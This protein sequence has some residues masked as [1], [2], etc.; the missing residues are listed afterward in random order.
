MNETKKSP[1]LAS[2]VN[3]ETDGFKDDDNTTTMDYAQ[4][5]DKYLAHVVENGTR[6]EMKVK[7]VNLSQNIYNMVFSEL[8]EIS[9]GVSD[10]ECQVKIRALQES[11]NEMTLVKK[12]VTRKLV[13]KNSINY[14]VKGSLSKAK[15]RE[16]SDNESDGSSKQEEQDHELVDIDLDSEDDLVEYARKIDCRAAVK[17]RTLIDNNAPKEEVMKVL[18]EIITIYHADTASKVNTVTV[19]QADQKK[20]LYKTVKEVENNKKKFDKKLQKLS[21]EVAQ[22]TAARNK[23]SGLIENVQKALI[24]RA[25]KEPWNPVT[26]AYRLSKRT[27]KTSNWHCYYV[28]ENLLETFEKDLPGERIADTKTMSQ[29]DRMVYTCR[30]NARVVMLSKFWSAGW[31]KHIQDFREW[32]TDSETHKENPC[33]SMVQEYLEKTLQYGKEDAEQIMKEE[34]LMIEPGTEKQN[35]MADN[36]NFPTSLDVTFVTEEAAHRVLTG[37]K[38][39]VNIH[40]GMPKGNVKVRVADEMMTKYRWQLFKQMELK[41]NF[42]EDG[43]LHPDGSRRR[44]SAC[45]RYSTKTQDGGDPKRVGIRIYVRKRFGPGSSWEHAKDADDSVQIPTWVEEWDQ[46]QYGRPEKYM[47]PAQAEVYDPNVDPKGNRAQESNDWN[48]VGRGGRHQNL[49]SKLKSRGLQQGYMSDSSSSSGSARSGKRGGRGG[50]GRGGNGNNTGRGKGYVKD[51]TIP[52]RGRGRG[53]G[54]GVNDNPSYRGRS[55]PVY[56]NARNSAPPSQQLSEQ[57][58]N[59]DGRGLPGFMSPGKA[60]ENR[61]GVTKKRVR[62]DG[63]PPNDRTTKKIN[64]E[65]LS[66]LSAD[67]KAARLSQAQ[68]EAAR[69]DAEIK[70]LKPKGR[71]YSNVEVGDDIVALHSWITSPTKNTVMKSRAMV[72]LD[73]N[74]YNI[75]HCITN[76]NEISLQDPERLR[77]DDD[78]DGEMC[79]DISNVNMLKCPDR[80]TIREKSPLEEVLKSNFTISCHNVKN[81][82]IALSSKNLNICNVLNKTLPN[83]KSEINSVEVQST[84]TKSGFEIKMRPLSGSN[85]VKVNVITNG[86]D[87]VAHFQSNQT[88]YIKKTYAIHWLI[89]HLM[90]EQIMKLSR[91]MSKTVKRHEK[92]ENCNENQKK[93]TCWFC[94]ATVCESCFNKSARS[95]KQCPELTIT[96]VKLCTEETL[97]NNMVQF[98]QSNKQRPNSDEIDKL[99]RMSPKK[100]QPPVLQRKSGP[101]VIELLKRQKDNKDKE[102]PKTDKAINNPM[103]MQQQRQYE[104]VVK[105]T[106]T[107]IPTSQPEKSKTNAESGNTTNKKQLPPL[108]DLKD[109]LKELD[110]P[111]RLGPNVP[112]DGSCLTHTMQWFIQELNFEEYKHLD[113]VGLRAYI[114]DHMEE[115]LRKRE[116]F[117]V[118]F[119]DYNKFKVHVEESRNVGEWLGAVE[120]ECFSEMINREIIIFHPWCHKGTPFERTVVTSPEFNYKSKQVICMGLQNGN[121]YRPLIETG[122]NEAIIRFIDH[123]LVSMGIITED[124]PTDKVGGWRQGYNEGPQL[125]RL[126]DLVNCTDVED[127]DKVKY[128]TL[129]ASLKSIIGQLSYQKKLNDDYRKLLEKY[130]TQLQDKL[131]ENGITIPGN[132]NDPGSIKFLSLEQKL[133]KV[134]KML[135][136]TPPN[137]IDGHPGNTGLMSL[138]Q[139]EDVQ[140]GK[141]SVEEE[142]ISV[143]YFNFL[144]SKMSTK[145]EVC[146]CQ[147]RLTPCDKS[148]GTCHCCELCK[149]EKGYDSCMMKLRKNATME[150]KKGDVFYSV[151]AFEKQKGPQKIKNASG[152]ILLNSNGGGGTRDMTMKEA[153]NIAGNGHVVGTFDAIDDP[154]SRKYAIMRKVPRVAG[155]EAALIDDVVTGASGS[156]VK[157]FSAGDQRAE[158]FNAPTGFFL[159]T[160]YLS[161]IINMLNHPTPNLSY[162][163]LLTT[164]NM[165]VMNNKV[166]VKDFMEMEAT[167]FYYLGCDLEVIITKL[168]DMTAS[169][170]VRHAKK[171]T[172]MEEAWDLSKGLCGGQ[173][174]VIKESKPNYDLF[175]KANKKSDPIGL[176]ALN[177]QK[178]NF[179]NKMAVKKGSADHQ[180][181]QS[182]KSE[183]NQDQFSHTNCFNKVDFKSD[184]E[185]S[186]VPPTDGR[187]KRSLT[188]VGW[189]CE[190][191]EKK[192]DVIREISEVYD[193]DIITTQET[194]LTTSTATEFKHAVKGYTMSSVS[195]DD[196]L[197]S[198]DEKDR[199][200][201]RPFHGVATTMKDDLFKQSQP[202]DSGSD[203][204]L[205]QKINLGKKKILLLNC[206]LP[207]RGN[208]MAELKAFESCLNR[209]SALVK[210][211][212]DKN[213]SFILFSDWN[214]CPVRHNHD[215]KRIKAMKSF[216]EE[217]GGNYFVPEV[218]SFTPHLG[219]SSWLDGIITSKDIEM[220]Y[221]LTLDEEYF[222]SSTS[223]HCPVIAGLKLVGEEKEKSGKRKPKSYTPFHQYKRP[224][225]G[226]INIEM[227]QKLSERLIDYTMEATEDCSWEVRTKIFSDCLAKAAHLATMSDK[228][229]EAEQ[230]DKEKQRRDVCR[231]EKSFLQHKFRKL[232]QEIRKKLGIDANEAKKRYPNNNLVLRLQGLERD[233]KQKMRELRRFER[234]IWYSKEK[235]RLSELNTNLLKGNSRDFHKIIEKYKGD[236]GDDFPD[237]LIVNGRAYLGDDVLEG[238]QEMAYQQSRKEKMM[239]MNV[240][241]E[242]ITIKK[243]NHL[244]ENMVEMDDFETRRLSNYEIM[245]ELRNI[246]DN[247]APDLANLMKENITRNSKKIQ[248]MF[249]DIINDMIQTP[250]NYS[251]SL[252]ST[253]VASFLFKGKGKDRLDPTSYRK[254]SIGSIYNKVVDKIYSHETQEVAK[255]NQP[256]TQFGFTGG[257]NFL[258]CTILREST[259]RLAVKQGKSPILLA[260]DVK[261]AFS[262]TSRVCQMYELYNAG[263]RSKVWKYSAHTYFNTFT[264]IKN[265]KKYSSL[266]EEMCGSKQGGVK[267]AVDYKSYN[268]P[269]YHLIE[270]SGL[271][272]KIGNKKFGSVIVADDALSMSTTIPQMKGIVELYEYFANIYSVDYCVKKTVINR[273]GSK[274]A[275]KELMESDLTVGGVTPNFDEESL[276][277]GLWISEKLNEVGDRNVDARIKKT[278][279][280]LFGHLRNVI[281]DKT[282]LASIEVK[283]NIYKTLLRPSL[284]SGINALHLTKKS[285]SKLVDWEN[286]FLRKVFNLKSNASTIG[287]MISC[288][289]LPIEG[290]L[291]KGVLSLWYNAWANSDNPVMNIIQ[292]TLNENPE[293][294]HWASFLKT[295]CNKY[296]ISTPDVMIKKKLPS[297]EGWKRYVD[298]KVVKYHKEILELRKETMSTLDLHTVEAKL[299]GKLAECLMSA[300]GGSQA[301]LKYIMKMSIGEFE[302]FDWKKRNNYAISDLCPFCKGGKDNALHNLVTCEKVNEDDRVQSSRSTLMKTWR[303]TGFQSADKLQHAKKILNPSLG[304]K[305]SLP[306]VVSKIY[307]ESR[308]LVQLI[309]YRYKELEE[310][311]RNRATLPGQGDRPDQSRTCQHQESKYGGYENKENKITRYFQ[312]IKLDQVGHPG[313]VDRPRRSPPIPYG[314]DKDPNADTSDQ[315]VVSI[316]NPGNSLVI[317]SMTTRY[318]RV[319]IW[320]EVIRGEGHQGGK[321]PWGRV[322]LVNSDDLDVISAARSTFS[323]AFNQ[324]NGCKLSQ[325]A[326]CRLWPKN[327]TDDLVNTWTGGRWPRGGKNKLGPEAE[328]ERVGVWTLWIPDSPPVDVYC[329]SQDDDVSEVFLHRQSLPLTIQISERDQ[330]RVTDSRNLLPNPGRFLDLEDDFKKMDI[331]CVTKRF[332]IDGCSTA[333]VES[334]LERW[335]RSYPGEMTPSQ[336]DLICPLTDIEG[337]RVIKRQPSYYTWHDQDVPLTFARISTV[338]PANKVIDFV[339]VDDDMIRVYDKELARVEREL[340][341]GIEETRDKG[342][343]ESLLAGNMGGQV[344]PFRQRD[345][346]RTCSTQ[347]P[348]KFHVMSDEQ[349]KA[350]NEYEAKVA[351]SLRTHGAEI[352]KFSFEPTPG[353][354]RT[355]TFKAEVKAELLEESYDNDDVHKDEKEATLEED[356]EE[357]EAATKEEEVKK[358]KRSSTSSSKT[359]SRSAKKSSRKTKPKKKTKRCSSSDSSDSS[360]TTSS[361]SDDSSSSEDE[362]KKAKRRDFNN[363]KDA[364]DLLRDCKKFNTRIPR[365]CVHSLKRLQD[366]HKKKKMLTELKVKKN[367]YTLLRKVNNPKPE[368]KE[369]ATVIEDKKSKG[370]GK[371]KSSKHEK[372]KK[373]KKEKEE[374]KETSDHVSKHL[375]ETV[376]DMEHK[377]DEIT[378]AD[379]EKLHEMVRSDEANAVLDETSSNDED[380][381]VLNLHVDDED[382]M[383]G[384]VFG[385]VTGT[386][387]DC[388]RSLT[389]VKCKLQVGMPA[390][391]SIH[392][393]GNDIFHNPKFYSLGNLSYNLLHFRQN[394]SRGPIK[395]PIYNARCNQVQKVITKFAFE[396]LMSI[397]F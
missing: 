334:L 376:S 345:F 36:P 139:C 231:H 307:T 361:S 44:W 201:K 126:R 186:K 71:L 145:L 367:I 229:S 395:Q 31:K 68:A 323:T 86:S 318:G 35:R 225:W 306:S 319:T 3:Q 375:L 337:A 391:T 42:A 261:N 289:L 193:P 354:S 182:C 277:L 1:I 215:K 392:F 76:E 194:Y 280:K 66:K 102:K 85:F 89:E 96:A 274:Q 43:S 330:A 164:L 51:Q 332:P 159:K 258:L 155:L 167:C 67:E 210:E 95:C 390:H 49:V 227:Y 310:D 262:K 393:A 218:P 59:G 303:Q 146:M 356:A 212:S 222:P 32:S 172:A 105:P 278:E 213:T 327:L 235:K 177:K 17:I 352:A 65:D 241:T 56:S 304:L 184:T 171:A 243:F 267:S 191:Y 208:L 69:L 192:M 317:G 359:P 348:R 147:F 33:F 205:A 100:K 185:I 386:L 153:S 75:F 300:R 355:T 124:D 374:T 286:W 287:V 276:H 202:V 107:Y 297:K 12:G 364:I 7:D 98:C 151:A 260:C 341:A 104:N 196:F 338:R 333:Q 252:C 84:R 362:S 94:T 350:Y 133:D 309:V 325:L 281:W 150:K 117:N 320:K 148:Q 344:I 293:E 23:G 387:L 20:M 116:K 316:L 255:K 74:R 363:P 285:I 219:A 331:N 173:L 170:R 394:L 384:K 111:W 123:G 112:G 292:K 53:H 216:L 143:T 58:L 154:A 322:L 214:L 38:R 371:G 8:A 157:P 77:E 246:K 135:S 377:L 360:D 226:N 13:N 187:D 308:N 180:N 127:L 378:S 336:S 73:H 249:C 166:T 301:T 275:K 128:D 79:A 115:L 131:S 211:Q 122:N 273:F 244:Y 18:M 91:S 385:N 101:S 328:E 372:G 290:H 90:T 397:M 64:V 220:S 253:S 63:T 176:T 19:E 142:T 268:S 21:N 5:A 47:T 189:N 198:K 106:S 294:G 136:Q 195:K 158:V 108:K 52:P 9:S 120:I 97:I 83:M 379:E 349:W 183:H 178:R 30:F 200:T 99:P 358:R 206:Y 370:K 46:E 160:N 223:T 259:V 380:P 130:V 298:E 228:S 217:I 232:K 165:M 40:N 209:I 41:E 233:K 264:V 25:K 4:Q 291:H 365:D 24:A 60:K 144:V 204:I 347:V 175:S 248:T 134:L 113:H 224:N 34:V 296:R 37:S 247:K 313:T 121:H 88:A 311:V 389:R 118:Y 149:A 251:S 382:V 270:W 236:N 343:D 326:T 28:N 314:I 351:Q 50:P 26:E 335:Y 11:F 93:K 103:P 197:K 299:D 203:R 199:F 396:S 242:F 92:C 284:L 78:S 340:L 57:D 339:P 168:K 137:P 288:G 138:N 140:L 162:Q 125:E 70:A 221:L 110:A 10:E 174:E 54:S 381:N 312:T 15:S 305:T 302:N 324:K 14:R 16:M 141:G 81:Y 369:S 156:K 169:M 239:D 388:F 266:I 39:Y 256:E 188:L 129:I 190:N 263:E 45:T 61:K 279:G 27:T 72:A 315:P 342:N 357:E 283:M 82:S 368:K 179:A 109:V 366:K 321:Q 2:L 234:N 353:T 250:E 238:F 346:V 237:K 269:L 114:C 265:G 257:V 163:K 80:G 6:N 245:K 373:C 62:S 254:I 329:M 132:S 230:E 271:G 207:T 181:M 282:G 119:T 87:R 161:S 152:S 55:V 295:V 22:N 383:T 240:P 29:D 48:V 272:M